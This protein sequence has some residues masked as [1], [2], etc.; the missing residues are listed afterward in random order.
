MLTKPDSYF[1]M[2]ALG[3]ADILKAAFLAIAVGSQGHPAWVGIYGQ[4]VEM[5]NF[6]EEID[7]V[8]QREDFPSTEG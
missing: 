8:T 6:V 1:T 7:I 2:S 5:Y 3:Q 4:A